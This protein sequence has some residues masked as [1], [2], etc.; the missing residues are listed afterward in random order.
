MMKIYLQLGTKEEAGARWQK[1]G[2]HPLCKPG[3]IGMNPYTDGNIPIP[4]P[5][6]DNIVTY[7]QV[8]AAL[9]KA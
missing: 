7:A 1:R 4:I 6:P 8:R 9:A 5:E 2:P 3:Q